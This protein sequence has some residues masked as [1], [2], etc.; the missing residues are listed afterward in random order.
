MNNNDNT[1]VVKPIVNTL[2]KI[3][4]YSTTIYIIVLTMSICYN[5]GYLKQ[6]NS[7]IIDLIE[8][9]DYLNDSVHN[10]WFFVLGALLLFIG[11]LTFTKIVKEEGFLKVILFGTCTFIISLYFLLKGIYDSKFWP[12]I[13]K[14]LDGNDKPALLIYL[15]IVIMVFSF[16][17][18]YYFIVFRSNSQQEKGAISASVTPILFF[19]FLVLMPYIGGIFQGYIENKYLTKEFYK[20]ILSVDMCIVPGDEI[21]ENVYIVKKLGKG[22]LIQQFNDT[23]GNDTFRFINWGNIKSITYKRVEEL[24]SPV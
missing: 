3:T 23:E 6:I 22:I 8:L 5:I 1:A 11:S 13:K 2:S 19:F 16:V 17:L 7:Q 24:L 15:Y 14:L 21:L 18:F 9:S 4:G 12:V 10:I 20:T